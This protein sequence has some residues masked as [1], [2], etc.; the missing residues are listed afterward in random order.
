MIAGDVVMY[1]LTDCVLLTLSLVENED[2]AFESD[3]FDFA[4]NPKISCHGFCRKSIA[5]QLVLPPF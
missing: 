2:M 5:L 4:E 3:F 1:C